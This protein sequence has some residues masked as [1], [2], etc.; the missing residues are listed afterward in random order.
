MSVAMRLK[1]Y[2]D[3]SGVCYETVP[4][5]RSATS[6]E[7]ARAAHVPQGRVAKGIVLEDESGYVLAVLPASC[8]LDL[9]SVRRSL[10]RRLQLANESRLEVLFDDC[11]VGAVPAMG[12]PYGIPALVDDSLLR[13]PDLYFAA[14]DH[15]EFVHLSGTAFRALHKDAE[16]GCIGRPH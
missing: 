12:R 7:S 2:L 4:H 15:E 3:A 14:G 1:G 10:K 6:L 9:G 13:M 8:R 11:E 16:H 5:P